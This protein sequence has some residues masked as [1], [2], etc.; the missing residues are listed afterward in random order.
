MDEL[1]SA[2]QD[3]AARNHALADPCDDLGLSIFVTPGPTKMWLSDTSER[4]RQ[5]ISGEVPVPARGLVT[6]R[7]DLP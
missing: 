7:A 2:A 5:E 3:L 1:T 4:P 6:L